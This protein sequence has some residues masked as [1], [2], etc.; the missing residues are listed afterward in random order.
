MREQLVDRAV[1]VRGQT[2]EHIA[3]VGPRV[4]PVELGGLDQAHHRRSTLAGEFA[5][6]EQPSLSS[7]RP[8]TDLVFKVVVV[9]RDVAVFEEATERA[10][11]PEAVN[12]SPRG[13]A[14]IGYSTSL[15]FQPVVQRIPALCRER[16]S[17][18]E[19]RSLLKCMIARS[20][21]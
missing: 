1:E 18:L 20:I 21:R 10:P 8:W 11:P 14:S 12:Q 15:E 5:T 4:V 6:G 16:L 13:R 9:E 2:F 19:R 17:Y 3:Q 7:N